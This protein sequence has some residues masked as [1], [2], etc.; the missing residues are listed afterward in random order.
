MTEYEMMQRERARLFLWRYGSM[1]FV[2]RVLVESECPETGAPIDFYRYE[3][4]ERRLRLHA[5]LR[6]GIHHT[7]PEFEILREHFSRGL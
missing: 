1:C 3:L 6:A 5:G 7:D 2:R 4:D